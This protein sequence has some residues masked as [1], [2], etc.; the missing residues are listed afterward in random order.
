MRIKRAISAENNLGKRHMREENCSHAYERQILQ[1]AR[2]GRSRKES[3]Q[4]DKPSVT[5]NQVQ[6]QNLNSRKLLL[7]EDK[8]RSIEKGQSKTCKERKLVLLGNQPFVI[9]TR[10]KKRHVKLA[11]DNKPFSLYNGAKEKKVSSRK[12]LLHRMPPNFRS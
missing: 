4:R 12:V 8:A 1:G 10:A 2:Q 11:W 7:H 5:E 6:E 9:N 3:L